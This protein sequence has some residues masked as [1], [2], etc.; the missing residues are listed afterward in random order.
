MTLTEPPRAI[1]AKRRDAASERA[2]LNLVDRAISDE[3]VV[4]LDGAHRAWRVGDDFDQQRRAHDLVMPVHGQ[5]LPWA[6]VV[7]ARVIADARCAAHS[8]DGGA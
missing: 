4:V 5:L 2:A 8:V 7:V 1:G 6:S 3:L